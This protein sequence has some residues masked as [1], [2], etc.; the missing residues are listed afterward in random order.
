MQCGG[1]W[2][3]QLFNSFLQH[4][5]EKFY[6]PLK[7][8]EFLSDCYCQGLLPKNELFFSSGLLFS[9]LFGFW[10]IIFYIYIVLF[11]MFVPFRQSKISQ[12]NCW[13]FSFGQVFSSY[14]SLSL[15]NMI[16]CKFFYVW[17]PPHKVK[18]LF[19]VILRRTGWG[20]TRVTPVAPLWL[21]KNKNFILFYLPVFSNTEL[22]MWAFRCLNNLQAELQTGKSVSPKGTGKLGEGLA[23]LLRNLV[24]FACL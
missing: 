20:N 7:L 24:R 4:A 19:L 8:E 18:G 9:N 5:P 17:C 14:N 2:H 6:F 13:V 11:T 22:Q 16:V 12:V 21:F 3:F 23:G 1:P 15:I 10:S